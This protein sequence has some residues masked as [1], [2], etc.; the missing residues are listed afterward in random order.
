MK[1]KIVRKIVEIA[2]IVRYWALFILLGVLGFVTY[3]VYSFSKPDNQIRDTISV[4]TGGAVLITLFY[5]FINYEYTQRKF[6]YDIKSSK[7]LLSF[8]IAMEW[9]KEHMTKNL[10]I[11]YKFYCK[12]K[13]LL[14]DGKCRKFQK[15]L[16]SP[17]YEE[18][19]SS[20]LVVLNFME[21]VSLAVKQGIMD[22]EFIKGF[23]GSVFIMQY[24]RYQPYIEYRR[25]NIQNPKIWENFTYLSNKWLSCN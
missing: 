10:A 4:F 8:N 7:D 21:S 19:Y 17:E 14:E 20:L 24:N 25:K 11:L 12:N 15:R 3:R 1:E 5:Y 16:D 13:S 18:S 22:E 2:F 9:Q 23:F 6:K